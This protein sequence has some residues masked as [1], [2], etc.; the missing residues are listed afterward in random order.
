MFPVL[1]VISH[2]P[3]LA[4]LGTLML[5]VEVSVINTFSL[6]REPV[7]LPVLVLMNSSP[8][9]QPCRS[10]LPVV[11][12]N[13]KACEA[14]TFV[15]ATLPVLPSVARLLQVVSVIVSLPVLTFAE[16]SPLQVTDSV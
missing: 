6:S 4:V 12:S 10:M 5:P 8:A 2:L 15:S 1:V 11:L 13:E 16:I 7:T 14:I 3:P 9:S